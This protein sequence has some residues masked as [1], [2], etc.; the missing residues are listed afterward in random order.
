MKIIQKQKWARIFLTLALPI[1]LLLGGCTNI[2]PV[3]PSPNPTLP[4]KPLTDITTVS[5]TYSYGPT[6]KVL[7][8]SNNIIIKVGQKLT[9]EPA[10]GLTTNTRFTSSGENFFGDVMKQETGG[11]D[12]TKASFIAIAPGKGKLTII[13]NTNDNARATDLWVTVQ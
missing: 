8:S 12:D 11:Q 13:P 1:M 7:L 9:L 4:A 2:T 6:D 10:P 5:I 3:D